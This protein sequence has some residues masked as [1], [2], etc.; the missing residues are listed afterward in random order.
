MFADTVGCNMTVMPLETL[1]CGE[2]DIAAVVG[3]GLSKVQSPGILMTLAAPR[4][5]S[6]LPYFLKFN[7]VCPLYQAD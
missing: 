2:G 6:T 1:H 5:S 7:T 3:V 4:C